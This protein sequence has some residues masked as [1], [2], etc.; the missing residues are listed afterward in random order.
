MGILEWTIRSAMRNP[1]AQVFFGL[2]LCT[3]ALTLMLPVLAPK[4]VT[5]TPNDLPPALK[6]HL[7]RKASDEKLI[8]Y[9]LNLLLLGIAMWALCLYLSGGGEELPP[10]AAL[11]WSKY[12]KFEIGMTLYLLAILLSELKERI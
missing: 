3:A 12:L 9:A 10:L 8:S 6:G 2:A 7:L 5:S 11:S 1:D 4:P